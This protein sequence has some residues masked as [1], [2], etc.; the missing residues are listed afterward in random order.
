MKH[1]ALCLSI[2][3]LTGCQD[4]KFVTRYEYQDVI[5]VPPS[6]DLIE[7][8]QPFNQPPATYGDAVQR[9]AI[10]LTY[11]RLCACQLERNR[12][13]YGYDNKN[14]ACSKLDSSAIPSQ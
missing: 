4:T 6:S 14:G 8:E 2:I 9:D 3:L 13:F 11:F 1:A 7:C 10:W 5:R 12:S